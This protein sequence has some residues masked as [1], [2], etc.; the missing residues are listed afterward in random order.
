MD[1]GAS[2]IEENLSNWHYLLS[3]FWSDLYEKNI[4]WS[5]QNFQKYFVALH[6]WVC[7]D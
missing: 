5:S 2:K 4:S 1:I 6:L 7:V 3:Y